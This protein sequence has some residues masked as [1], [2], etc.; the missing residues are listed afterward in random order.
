MGYGGATPSA[1]RMQKGQRSRLRRRASEAIERGSAEVA[2]DEDRRPGFATR[3]VH[4]ARMPPIDQDTPSVPIFQSSTFRFET[5]E[6]YADTISFR[7]PGYT[8]TRGYGNPTLAAFETLMADLEQTESAFSFASGMAAIHTVATTCAGAGDRIVASP[9]LYGGTF[10][11]FRNVLPRYGIEVTFV[12]AHDPDA[13]GDALPGAKLFYC[14]TIANPN[15]TVVDLEALSGLCQNAGVPAAVD[16]TFA[17]PYLC[18]PARYGFHH[19]L[20]SATKYVGGHHD[21]IGGVVCT[22][23]EGMHALRETA[24]DT[25]GT[26]APF[27]AWLALR[28]LMTLPLRMEQHS[29]TALALA[30]FL[31][32]HDKAERVH[33]PG[34]A[35]HPHHA[36]ARRQFGERFGGM[37]AV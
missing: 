10:S 5:S 17:S 22:S 34:L 32:G 11:L 24:I 23:E 31:E 6:R 20:H 12:D 15:V 29:R 27:E 37:L 18:T 9:E 28:G 36:V 30:A 3:A 8:Y 35:S 7:R 16:N 19:V 4:G 21:L 26:M 1:G 33:Y 2:V 14:E 13:V 25:G